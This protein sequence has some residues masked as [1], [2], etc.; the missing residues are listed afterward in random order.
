RRTVWSPLRRVCARRARAR[1]C[2]SRRPRRPRRAWRGVASPGA[3]WLLP[4]GWSHTVPDFERVSK[5]AGGYGLPD[6]MRPD[7]VI[8]VSITPI[9]LDCARLG[10]VARWLPR[11]RELDLALPA[12][13][14]SGLSSAL[15]VPA[16]Q[17]V[18]VRGE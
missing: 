6:R 17:P 7:Q 1:T 2:L 5:V 12:A 10:R 11:A 16:P 3:S 13:R 8:G 9:R 14:S 4:G 18:R 15:R